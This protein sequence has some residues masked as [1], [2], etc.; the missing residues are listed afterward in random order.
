MELWILCKNYFKFSKEFAN[1]KKNLNHIFKFHDEKLAYSL[2]SVPFYLNICIENKT[3]EK[4]TKK[5]T[6]DDDSSFSF[7]FKTTKR[8]IN[9]RNQFRSF[10][11]V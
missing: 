1:I 3:M 5:K 9:T 8:Q 11:N 4:T 6:V 10:K 2:Y 7:A